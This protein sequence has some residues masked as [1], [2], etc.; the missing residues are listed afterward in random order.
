MGASEPDYRE[1]VERIGDMIYTLDLD[2]RFTYV[3]SSGLALLGYEAS[4]L[5]GRHFASVLTG[6][7]ASVAADHFARGIDGTESTPFFEVQSVR[8]DGRIVDL[9]VRAGNLYREGRLVGRQGVAR[10][11]SALKALQ[12]QVAEKSERLALI[13]GQARVAMDL[14]R[15][16][17]ELTL[18]TPADPEATDRVL[19]GV[20]DS[21]IRASAEKLG[22]DQQ[23]LAIAELLAEGYSNAEI[24]ARVH[25]SPSTVKDRVSKLMRAL[26]ARSRAEVVARAARQGL[27]VGDGR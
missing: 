22:L 10:D 14:Y 23:D 4:E 19:R 27:F 1:L 24:G 2:G 7:S 11:I 16:I 21:L 12:A 6:Q 17:A 3:N 26:G 20:E 18:A 13:E 25:L 8:T 5:L 15:R 9:E